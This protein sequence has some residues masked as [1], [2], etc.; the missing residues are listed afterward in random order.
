M[1]LSPH[2]CNQ[3]LV[4]YSLS[5]NSEERYSFSPRLYLYHPT[6]DM[7]YPGLDPLLLLFR[8]L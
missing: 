2:M 5:L 8:S 3:Y 1:A 4:S 7:T 6:K